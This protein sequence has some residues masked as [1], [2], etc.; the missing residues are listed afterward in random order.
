MLV[1]RFANSFV[2]TEYP[3]LFP[4]R[5]E[6]MCKR[7]LSRLQREN[8]WTLCVVLV[9]KFYYSDSERTEVEEGE[10]SSSGAVIDTTHTKSKPSGYI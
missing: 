10:S 1:R 6:G 7:K 3:E 2:Y 9:L 4:T 8:N 5:T